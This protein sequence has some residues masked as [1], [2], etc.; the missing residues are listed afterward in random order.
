MPLHL[1]TD[2]QTLYPPTRQFELFGRQLGA[3]ID[4]RRL[5]IGGAFALVWVVLLGAV[6]GVPF[7]GRMGLML[8]IVPPA[9]LAV[10]GTRPGDDG[11][12]ALMRGYDWLLARRRSRRRVLRNPAL[13][14]AARSA[15]PLR[16]TVHTRVG[17]DT[18]RPARTR[19]KKP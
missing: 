15:A 3:G 7:L 19:G 14:D 17:T 8:Y 11:R 6:L 10:L 1:P 9:V 16:L 5:L 13:P 18:P 12:M 2:T 4:R